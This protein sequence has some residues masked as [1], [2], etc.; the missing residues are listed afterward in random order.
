M[1]K[2]RASSNS[3]V[4]LLPD[5]G[6]L[7]FVGNIKGYSPSLE[8]TNNPAWAMTAQQP[9]ACHY[10]FLPEVPTVPL[11][12]WPQSVVSTERVIGLRVSGELLPPVTQCPET[13]LDLTKL[14][15][16]WGD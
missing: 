11:S 5:S 1:G 9:L 4:A 10:T 15:I 16:F 14:H 2:E 8:A 7:R 13:E 12:S 6:R 3:I